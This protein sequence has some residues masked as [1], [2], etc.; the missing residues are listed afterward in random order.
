MSKLNSTW[1]VQPHGQLEQVS[2]GLFSVQG[3]IIMPLGKFPRRMTVVALRGGGSLIWSAIPLAESEMAKIEALGQVRFIIVPNKAHRLD[4][5]PWANRYPEAQIIAPP[6][7]VS[8]VAEAE[9]VAASGDII[10]DPALTLELIPGLKADEF[11][12]TVRRDGDTTL[13]LN[14]I[15]A[16]VAHPEGLGATIMAHFFGFGVTRPRTSRPVR[17]M[18][19][20]DEAAVANKFRMW[21]LIP[22]LKRVIV[23][24]GDIIRADPAGALRRAAEDYD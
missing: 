16:H 21:A 19:V 3:S 1:I 15:L 6:E 24:H 17:R 9:G 22:D 14:D 20:K 7:A 10:H 23:A 11:A 18:F 5:R 2:E 13:V 12:L 8:S 4:L